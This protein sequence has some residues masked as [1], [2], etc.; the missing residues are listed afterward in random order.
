MR[1]TFMENSSRKDNI[2]E[3]IRIQTVNENENM[4]CN[5]FPLK[6]FSKNNFKKCSYYLIQFFLFLNGSFNR[7]FLNKGA[8]C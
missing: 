7:A 1:I 2:L 5:N 8:E 4:I 6:Q 3:Y